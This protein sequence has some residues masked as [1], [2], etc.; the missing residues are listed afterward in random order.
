MDD[1]CGEWVICMGM[2]SRR[3]VWLVGVVSRMWMESMDVASDCG[4]KEV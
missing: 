1:N 3:W 4:C 2:V